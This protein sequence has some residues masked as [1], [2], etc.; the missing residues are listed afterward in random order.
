[1]KPKARRKL[2]TQLAALFHDHLIEKT[3]TTL[4]K[5]R[6]VRTALA[7]LTRAERT[8]LLRAASTVYYLDAD[9]REYIT[10]QFKAWEKYSQMLGK[11]ILPH[12]STLSTIGAQVR[13]ME[14]KKSQE[15]DK[16]RNAP[17][18]KFLKEFYREDRHL[19]GLVRMT[20]Q[21]EQDVLAKQPEEF[22]RAYLKYK[23]VWPVVKELWIERVQA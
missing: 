9:P 20:R 8:A 3:M 7:D 13:Y 19:A 23:G 15:E 22:S 14:F 12:P 10:A 4:H 6:K 11:Y 1:M 17:T 2:A 18:E 16:D 5:G 21:M